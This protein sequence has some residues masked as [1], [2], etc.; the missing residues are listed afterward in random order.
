M[1]VFSAKSIN[2]FV[3]K[4]LVD[5]FNKNVVILDP[6]YNNT[7][8]SKSILKTFFNYIFHDYMLDLI[9]HSKYGTVCDFKSTI[10]FILYT[11][12]GRIWPYSNYKFINELDYI[13]TMNSNNFS[14]EPSI[15]SKKDL[16]NDII[17]NYIGYGLVTKKKNKYVIDTRYL[18]QFEVREGYSKLNCI[19]YLDDEQHFDYC[20]INGHKRIDDLAICECITAI[21][22]IITLEYHLFKIHILIGDKFNLLLNTL[23]R[24][25]PI[26]RILIPTTHSTYDVIEIGAITLLGQTGFCNFFNFTRKGL[27]Q[28]YE[29]IKLNFKIRDI[30][31]PKK[32]LGKSSVHEHQY[33][34]FN[35]IHNFVNNF[36]KSQTNLD[37]DNFIKLLNENY[38]GIYD[39][40][41][42]DME[43][44][45]DICAM[46]IYS[47]IIHESY[48][49]SKL[50]K[51]SMN[52]YTISTTWRENDS[53]VLDD[54]INSLSEQTIVNFIAYVTS[55]EAIPMNDERW[56][57]LC[58]INDTEKLIYN[59]F[60]TVIKNL[61]I[62]D[63]AILHPKNISSSLT[64]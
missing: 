34:W 6:V 58:C 37:S 13:T 24:T 8:P 20:K 56:I 53:L 64:Y 1:M 2:L 28:Y 40:T 59:N 10:N 38:D 4:F 36:L 25:N 49:N 5:Y 46:I 15:L 29:Y 31:I 43:N 62:P 45:I 19:I 50:S 17:D 27:E 52:P 23:E 51:I 21:S 39:K 11:I 42:C 12:I 30:L 60:R 7:Q 55:L 32:I 26:Y 16:F 9:P 41:K 3:F 33:L 44:I 18:Q 47:N 14:V 48:S 35:C 22:T 63:Y 57:N 61:D 54:K